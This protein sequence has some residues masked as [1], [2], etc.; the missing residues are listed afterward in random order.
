M[1][2]CACSPYPNTLPDDCEQPVVFNPTEPLPAMPEPVPDNRM[3][4]WQ[5]STQHVVHGL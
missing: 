1:L 5:A 4:A 3:T 2:S